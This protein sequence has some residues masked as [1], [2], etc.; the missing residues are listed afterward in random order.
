MKRIFESAG[1]NDIIRKNPAKKL[2]RG[3]VEAEEKT[4]LTS[5]QVET[6]ESAVKGTV[7]EAFV[8]IGLHAGLRCEEIMALQWSCVSLDGEAPQLSWKNNRPIVVDKLKSKASNRDIPIP[9]KLVEC[10]KAIKEKSNS[11]FVISNKSGG[12]RSQ[13][14]FANMWGVIESRSAGVGVYTKNGVKVEIERKLGEKCK[15]HN[16]FY[17]ID[18]HVTPHQLRHTYITNL[19][20][21][22]VN[23]KTV[24]YLAGHSDIKMTLRIY[25]H[26]M[27]NKP[28]D[29]IA[30]VLKAYA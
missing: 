4:A 19:I 27:E 21:S 25:T 2:T 13:T 6:L 18:F 20:L 28:K 16:F 14:Q 3:G 10:L 29:L 12:P 11:D 17:T 30:E 9:P 5:S 8:M 26:L 1:D 24:Q 15:R 7:A 23:I 22:G